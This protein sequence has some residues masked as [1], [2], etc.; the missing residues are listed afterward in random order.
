MYLVI[1]LAVFICF[2]KGKKK[3]EA[4]ISVESYIVNKKHLKLRL[5]KSNSYHSI[6]ST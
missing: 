2:E 4:L 1:T 3:K 5:G 6:N